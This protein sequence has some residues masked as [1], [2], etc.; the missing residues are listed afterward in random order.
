MRY[1][2]WDVLLF[3]ADSRVPLQEFD[4]KCFALDPSKYG[5]SADDHQRLKVV[6]S[7]ITT[8]QGPS[9][10]EIDNFESM[11]L[12]PTVTSFVASLERHTPFRISIHSWKKPMASRL[13]Q[14]YKTR[15]E[16]VMFEA[17]IYIDGTLQAYDP[18]RTWEAYETDAIC[19]STF[20]R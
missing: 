9:N 15:D 1:Q 7:R 10:A 17:R 16:R 8:L 3:P 11:T 12:V 2:N 20:F 13:L 6:G 4:T 5:L 19:Q 14:S 18:A